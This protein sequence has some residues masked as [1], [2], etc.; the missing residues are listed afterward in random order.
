[1]NSGILQLFSFVQLEMTMMRKSTKKENNELKKLCC[2]ERGIAELG[3]CF[4]LVFL[5]Y[6]LKKL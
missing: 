2:E 5:L 4:L 6:A 1:M 3:D